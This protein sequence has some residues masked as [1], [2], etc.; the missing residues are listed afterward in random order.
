MTK[1]VKPDL[2]PV[3]E[4]LL[5]PLLARARETEKGAMLRARMFDRHVEDFLA[6][7]PRGTVVEIGCRLDTRFAPPG[8]AVRP[9]PAA[10]AGV[11]V[12]VE[13]RHGRRRRANREGRRRG[14][15]N[16]IMTKLG[17][18]FAAC[19]LALPLPAGAVHTDRRLAV[20]RADADRQRLAGRPERLMEA[21]SFLTVPGG[22]GLPV[23]IKG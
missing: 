19:L 22:R 9:V 5:I 3:Q 16:D 6:A 12:S 8:G 2:V 13:S 23:G 17:V 21:L 10:G 11:L 15:G 7:H 4:T 1:P 18:S 14:R 20:V